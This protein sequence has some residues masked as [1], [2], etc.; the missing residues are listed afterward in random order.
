[1]RAGM[2]S[3]FALS[4]YLQWIQ[5]WQGKWRNWREARRLRVD[6]AAFRRETASLTTPWRLA[7]WA[8]AHLEEVPDGRWYDPP[9]E[10]A[11]TWS[12]RK[13]GPADYAALADRVLAEHGF[14]TL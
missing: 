11:V 3:W 14:T 2:K 4:V 8:E 9:Y 7:A 10:P 12:R 1:A 5:P 6:R 13:G